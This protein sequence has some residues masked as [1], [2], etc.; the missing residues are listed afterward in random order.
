MDLLNLNDYSIPE[1]ALLCSAGLLWI[2]IYVVVIQKAHK[3]NFAPVPALGIASFLAQEIL[4]GYRF[5]GDTGLLFY[6]GAKVYALLSGYILFRV[7]RQSH[8]YFS[9]PEFKARARTLTVFTF[10]AWVALL[11]FLIPAIDD[12]AGMTSAAIVHIVFAISFIPLLLKQFTDH[13][14]H[15]SQRMSYAI[16]WMKFLAGILIGV[17][18]LLHLPEQHWV[19]VLYGLIAIVDGYYIYLFTTLRRDHDAVSHP[20]IEHIQYKSLDLR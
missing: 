9:T 3:F 20:S 13:G 16:A 12:G 8:E 6:W 14:V 19:H 4:W 15:A 17:F 5:S 1:M 2:A 7:L 11:Y 10:V 18:A